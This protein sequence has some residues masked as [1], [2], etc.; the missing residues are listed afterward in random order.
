[1]K[2]MKQRIRQ[3]FE[4]AEM[5]T[6]LNRTQKKTAPPKNIENEKL[7]ELLEKKFILE[8]KKN[9]LNRLVVVAVQQN[10]IT[11]RRQNKLVNIFFNIQGNPVYQFLM[12][13]LV[14]G[15]IL[16]LA[17]DHYPIDYERLRLSEEW[18]ILFTIAYVSE[19]VIKVAG[20]GVVGYLGQTRFHYFEVIISILSIL[21]VVVT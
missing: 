13:L 21:D 15:N 10:M 17:Y 12:Q 16:N 1:M 2:K 9:M 6:F 4:Q 11:K 3:N 19:V 14:I 18:N 5:E 20:L 7:A 8:A